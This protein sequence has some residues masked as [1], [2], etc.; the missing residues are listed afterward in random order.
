V[1]TIKI[2]DPVS[3]LE[4]HLRV[5][6]TIE[7]VDNVQQVIDARASGTMFR[8][9]EMIL[10]GRP[11]LDAPHLTQRICGVCPVSHALVSVLALE[12]AAPV[13]VPDNARLMR[14]LVL[15]AS[16]L[17]SH[18]LHFY[19]LSLLDF[20]A[21][22]DRPPW[23]PRWS[24]DQRINGA[25]AQTLVDHYVQ[26]LSI[27][28]KAHEAGAA[29]GG[30]MP[31]PPTYLPGGFTTTP[32][33]SRISKCDGLVDEIIAFI[34]DTWI[35]DVQS[36]AT[37]YSDYYAI[38]GGPGN[39]L[40]LGAFDL[41]GS[42]SNRLFERGR[43]EAGIAGVQAVDV[44]SITEA[45]EYSWYQDAGAPR[46]PAQGQ[47]TPQHPKA[48]AYSWMKAPRYAAKP[49]EVGPLARLW[50]NGEYTNGISVLDR[51]LARAEESL[52]IA[53]A[54]KG[55]LAEL[56]PSGPVHTEYSVPANGQGVGLAEAPRGALGHW[57]SISSH[58]IEHYQVVTPTCWNASPRDE[59]DVLGPLE[60][61]LVGTPVADAD[62]P[63]EVLR[64]VHSPD[65]CLAC[66]V[67]VARPRSGRSLRV[68]ASP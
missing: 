2:L 12:R 29:F 6:V 15:G 8:G 39:L 20:V 41:D 16:F 28:R 19:H 21:G 1:A 68:V 34:Q 44:A 33:A 7:T 32:R 24:A 36:V 13:A 49:Y 30:R 59:A 54:M 61:A 47:T 18:V 57:V 46:N 52:K 35:P 48:E 9:F 31:H 23:T 45:V 55:W 37:A 25:A 10:E 67:H 60:Q 53:T 5:E 63:V 27:R 17:A 62:E 43:V 14:N 56:D 11:A 42:G 40:A 50:V 4:G 64:V 22:P 65:P 38:G 51:H 58:E 26:A 3:R 66:A